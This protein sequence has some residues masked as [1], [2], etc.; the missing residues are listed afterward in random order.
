MWGPN[1]ITETAGEGWFW[2]P[3]CRDQTRCRHQVV[4]R[5]FFAADRAIFPIKTLGE[6]IECSD[7]ENTFDPEVISDPGHAGQ[8]N[9]QKAARHLMAKMVLADGDVQQQ[10][11]RA[12]QTIHL[13]VTG[14]MLPPEEVAEELVMAKADNRS[15]SQYCQDVLGQ[16]NGPGKAQLIRAALMVALADGEY[17][18]DERALLH[19]I[20]TALQV[21]DE[22]LDTITGDL[23]MF[24][25]RTEEVLV[26]APTL[27]APAEI[28]EGGG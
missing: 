2:C 18:D 25:D 27:L 20:A 28:P 10:E 15:I 12:M 21:D 6:Y 5:W 8:A 19:E 3:T 13:M 23:M 16:V 1:D 14:A 26:E 11:Q 22:A 9:F 4:M 7:C 24:T 17:H